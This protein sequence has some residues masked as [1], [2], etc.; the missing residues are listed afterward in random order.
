MKLE[1]LIT[2]LRNS[3]DKREYAML[4][5]A[6]SLPANKFDRTLS[7]IGSVMAVIG[8][9]ALALMMLL[10][11]GDVA[12]RFFFKLPIEGAFEMIAFAM[13][14]AATWGLPHC[15]MKKGHIR[16]SILIEL[17]PEKAQELVN[18]I[19]Y[20]AGLLCFSLLL[21]NFQ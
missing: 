6:D 5:K 19:S 18:G 15:Q 10:T 4:K 21:R 9:G 14:F 7:A 1:D 12:G 3:R 20:L 16:I 13:V 2:R 8:A 17:F 11:V